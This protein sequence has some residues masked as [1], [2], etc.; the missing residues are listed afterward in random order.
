MRAAADRANAEARAEY[1]RR[2][3]FR[4]ETGA[5][6]EHDPWGNDPPP[7]GYRR[8]PDDYPDEDDGYEVADEEMVEFCFERCDRLNGRDREF[9]ESVYERFGHYGS[10]TPRQR[11][12]MVDIYERLRH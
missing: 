5:P 9:V 4:R 3:D 10:L 1:F 8:S 11:K 6:R 7:K 12:W 2:E